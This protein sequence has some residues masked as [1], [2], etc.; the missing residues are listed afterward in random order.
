MKVEMVVSNLVQWYSAHRRL[1]CPHQTMKL[2]I[3]SV[4]EY[5]FWEDV[6]D[7]NRLLIGND[8]R[9]THHWTREDQEGESAIDLTLANGSIVK[10]TVLADD[11]ATGSDLEVTKWEVGKTGRSRPIMSR[12]YCGLWLQ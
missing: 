1:Q 7:E 4:E 3:A 12:K 11:H 9:P 2:K 10:W 5:C 8:G 6:I